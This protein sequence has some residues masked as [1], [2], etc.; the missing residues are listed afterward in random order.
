MSENSINPTQISAP[1]AANE[2]IFVSAELRQV[3]AS[4][5]A[6]AEKIVDLGT[7]QSQEVGV[8]ALLRIGNVLHWFRNGVTSE[9]VAGYAAIIDA[10]NE[11]RKRLGASAAND[12]S[13][14]VAA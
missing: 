14:E 12:E 8:R 6:A 4:T 2:P 13:L 10:M 11:G 7:I 5:H 9:E 1:S 3:L